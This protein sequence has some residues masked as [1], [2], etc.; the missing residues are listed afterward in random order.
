VVLHESEDLVK[1]LGALAF[2]ALGEKESA[3]HEGKR[4]RAREGES[5]RAGHDGY[6]V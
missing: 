5:T 2:A 6:G 3:E 1:E 4:E